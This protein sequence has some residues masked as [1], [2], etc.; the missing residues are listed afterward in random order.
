MGVP[1]PSTVVAG[2]AV[3]AI[4]AFGCTPDATV[5]PPTP[6]R[7]ADDGPPE[8]PPAVGSSAAI[9]LPAGD[10]L[11]PAHLGILRRDVEALEATVGPTVRSLRTLSPSSVDLRRDLVAAFADR[12]SQVL[13]VVGPGAIELAGSFAPLHPRVRFCAV[14]GDPLVAADDG[15]PDGVVHLRVRVEELGHLVGVAARAAAAGAPVGLVLGEDDLAGERFRTGLLAGLGGAEVLE[16]APDDEA[17]PDAEV[18]ALRR[19]GASVV[20]VDGSRGAGSAAAAAARDGAKVIGPIG[21]VRTLPSAAVVASWR[22]DWASALLPTL[23]AVAA[24]EALASSSV[25]LAEEAFDLRLDGGAGAMV[26]SQVER[27]LHQ[28]LDGA[29]DPLARPSDDAVS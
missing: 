18:A 5:P 24:G 10:G 17:D 11:E 7:V 14:S 21:V 25:G 4:V 23:L 27:A 12:E 28:L 13:C 6:A 19:A 26:T 16:A 9:V 22:V 29:R 3:L 15:A 1:L 20:I 2:A 8:P